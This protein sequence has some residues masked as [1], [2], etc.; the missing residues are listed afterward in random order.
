MFPNV[1]WKKHKFDKHNLSTFLCFFHVLL[2]SSFKICGQTI[3]HQLL[4][5]IFQYCSL[6]MH[7]PQYCSP[8][9]DYSGKYKSIR[10]LLGK[11]I[12]RAAGAKQ[13]PKLSN[14]SFLETTTRTVSFLLTDDN[15]LL[16]VE[17]V[18]RPFSTTVL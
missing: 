16:Q 9:L 5:F 8:I 4:K 12:A 1:V 14:T 7:Y 3:H 17:E 2:F 11:Y 18:S 10:R 6:T 13:R 15:C